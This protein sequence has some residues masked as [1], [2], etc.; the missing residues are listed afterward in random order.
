MTLK[1]Q[2]G[3]RRAGTTDTERP[4]VWPGDPE[5]V[6]AAGI[7]FEA[8]AHVLANTCCWG[9]R[10]RAYHALA[11]HAVI[12]SEEVEA[13]DG[14]EDGDRR[15]LALHALI[16]DAPSAWLLPGGPGE[17]QRAAERRSRLAA[18]I[19]AALREA[20]GLD[21]VLADDHAELLRLVSRMTAAAERR[22]LG[23][24]DDGGV[25]FPPLKRR[26][27]SLGPG[28]AAKLWLARF[29]ALSAPPGNAS[30]A[31]AQANG[32]EGEGETAD[33]IRSKEGTD[34]ETQRSA[35]RFAA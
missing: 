32:T 12:V 35:L 18:G 11:A 21:A 6:A 15:R 30:E 31:Q 9:G 23:G 28:R 19:G 3:N 29:R 17:S 5:T 34:D 26:I 27:R 7:D 25:V 16:V 22:D 33:G 13:L 10:T 1:T 20:A 2:G 8:L 4:L 24:G 14:L